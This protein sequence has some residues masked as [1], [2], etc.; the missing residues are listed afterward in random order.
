MAQIVW[1]V[2]C[3][4]FTYFDFSC[5]SCVSGF[6]GELDYAWLEYLLKVKGVI[7]ERSSYT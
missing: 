5:N 2:C 7:L 3:L 6:V 1:L 4:S